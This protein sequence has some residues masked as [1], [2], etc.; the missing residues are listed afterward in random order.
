MRG[1]D[2]APAFVETQAVGCRILCSSGWL[3]LD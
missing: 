3:V 1:H 2:A